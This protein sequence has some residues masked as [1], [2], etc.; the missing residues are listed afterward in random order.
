M[1]SSFSIALSAL[2]AESQAINTTGNN[3]ANMNTDGFKESEVDFKDLFS[4]YYGTSSQV[5][6]GLGVSVPQGNQVFTQGSIESSQSPLD[7]AIQGNGFFVVQSASGQSLYTR[8]GNFTTNADGVLQTQTGETVQGWMATSGGSINT[9]GPTTAITLPTGQVLP[10]TA[11][12][13]FTLSAN[14]DAQAVAGTSTGTFSAPMQIVDS[15]GNTHNLTVT[16]TQSATSANTWNYNVTIPSGDLTGG[17]AGQQTSLLATPGS[18]TFNSDGTMSTTGGT[19]PVALNIN[20]LADGAANMNINW[21]LFNSN[22]QGNITEYAEASNLASS[23][24]DGN[25]AAQLTSVAIQSGGQVVATYSNGQTQ[26]EAQLAMASVEN[27]N[28]L[29]NV[30][31]NNYAVSSDTATPAVGVP[32]TGGRGQI[33][34]SSLESS[35]V[36]MATEFTHLIVYQSAYQASSRVISTVNTMNQDLFSLIH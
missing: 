32:Q 10:P 27:P 33:L 26:V 15:L 30:G 34:G 29:Q 31:N 7:A 14:L 6:T 22:G 36:D 28:S 21:N 8:D 5:Q 9:T 3:L 11:T 13:N 2:E 4:Q 25:Q 12:Q 23:S 35:N 16:F 17:T 19:A 24:Q 1:S 20:G 18:I